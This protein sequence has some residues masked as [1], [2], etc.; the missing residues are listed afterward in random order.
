MI[1]VVGIGRTTITASQAST[2]IFTSSTI[3]TTFDVI[4]PTPQVGELVITNKSLSTPTFT[5]VDPTK[6]ANNTGSWTYTSSD[7]T[8]ATVDGNNVTLLQAGIVTITGI[9]SSDSAYSSGFV[10]T[11][12]SI[13]PQG[14]VP[15]TFVFLKSNTIVSSVP[16]N[17]SPIS[18]A[19]TL[20]ASVSTPA[21]ILIFNPK[22]GTV[23]E[24]NKN[25][26][27]IINTLFNMF[28][29]STISIPSNL[30]FMPTTINASKM[31]IVKLV[32]PVGTT[33]NEPLVLNTVAADSATAFVCLIVDY[34]NSV[35]ING[36]G[37][38]AGFFIKIT[39][40]LYDKYAVVRTNKLNVST[41]SI[42]VAGDV[43]LF[44]G[45]T[46]LITGL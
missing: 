27:T 9:L 38:D 18:N 7:T 8:I 20:P 14:V 28:S 23:V 30:I 11:Q 31:K 6:P 35:Q 24:K 19:V 10:M 32:K 44:G 42:A 36:N 33:L 12:F 39:K 16:A 46:A 29:A 1:T 37:K 22:L 21:N 15:S 43:I 5:L 41:T 17:V 45:I 34:E 2:A 3:S 4:L 13:S 26:N 40:G 25:R